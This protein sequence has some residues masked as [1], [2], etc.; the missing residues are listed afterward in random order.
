MTERVLVRVLRIGSFHV[1][2]I[3]RATADCLG[4][5]AWMFVESDG[6]VRIIPCREVKTIGE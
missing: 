4:E 6:S 3:P 1:L 5:Y 2:V